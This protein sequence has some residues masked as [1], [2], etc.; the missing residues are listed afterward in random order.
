M[1][2]E[3]GLHFS[4]PLIAESPSPDTKVRFDYVFEDESGEEPG[5]R[6]SIRVELEYAFRPWLS[7]EGDFPYSVFDPDGDRTRSH[8]DTVEFGVKLASMAF[9]DHGILVGGGLELG[10]P[11]GDTSKRIG[12]SHLWEIE[13]FLDLGLKLGSF[14]LATF[15][16]PAIP[17]NENGEDEADLELG[18]NVSLLYHVTGRIEGLLEF[19]GERIFGGEEAGH[20]TAQITPGVKVAPFA[21]HPL[22]VGASVSFP[23]SADQDFHVRSFVSIFYHF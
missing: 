10:L 3:Q 14:E 9:A 4:H 21:N 6:H 2:F 19:D 15:I 20:T 17:T 1:G 22:K 5:K 11:T 13:P 18:W 12:S 23:I 8:F 7:V 16:S